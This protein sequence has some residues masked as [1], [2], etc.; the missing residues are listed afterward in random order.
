MADRDLFQRANAQGMKRFCE[1]WH[2]AQNQ[3]YL[4]RSQLGFSQASTPHQPA[5]CR[6]CENYHGIAYGYSRD[7][8]ARLICGIHPFGW[9]G[10][11]PCPDWRGAIEPEFSTA[12]SDDLNR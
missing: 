9:S 11:D 6:G 1:G 7:R 5:V 12:T 2:R 3:R 4:L 10:T 8:R